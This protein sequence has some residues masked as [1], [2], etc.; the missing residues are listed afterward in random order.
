MSLQG[1]SSEV[2]EKYSVQYQNADT[3][4]RMLGAIPKAQNI[5]DL[6]AKYRF[7]TMLDVGSGDGAVLAQL[8]TQKFIKNVSSVEISES[9]IQKIKERGLASLTEI[10]LFDGYVIPYSPKEFELATCSHVIEH[11]EHPRLLL[12]EIARVSD[13]Q[14]F[15]VPIDFSFF[16]DEKIQQFLDYGHINIYTPALFKFLLKSEGFEVI[17]ERFTF[18]SDEVLRYQKKS[19]L[20]RLIFGTKKIVMG[21]FPVIKKVK[22]S[23]Y[24]V[25]CKHTGELR[26]F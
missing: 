17:D 7:K 3:Q 16:V 21:I 9:G 5:I 1:V 4:W 11:V 13:Y 19:L 25:L 6:C 10:K 12:R 20:K 18:L 2:K 24:T 8:D 14:L 15:E 23:N 26:I 22:P